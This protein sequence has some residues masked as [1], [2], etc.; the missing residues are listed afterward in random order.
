MADQGIDAVLLTTEPNIFWFTGFLTPFWHSPTRPWFVVVPAEGKPIAVIP[1]IG[2]S[3][4][5]ETWIDDIRTWPSP[6][7]AD[8]GVSLL[9][10]VLVD[11]AGTDGT[12]GVLKGPETHLRM[13]L[14]DWALVATAHPGQRFVD[15]TPLIRALRMVKSEREIAKIAYLCSVVSDAFENLGD[16]LSVG[17]TE[18]AAFT[19]FR[20][21]LLQRGADEVPYLVGASGRDLSSI[22]SYPCDRT[23]EPGDLLMF[24]TGARRD[25]YWCDFDRNVA[26]GSADDEARRTY[27]VVW[28]ATEAGLGVLRPGITAAELYRAM[29]DVLVEGGSEGND[30][31]RLGH[32]LGLQL[33]EWPSNTAVDETVLTEN[34]VMTLEPGMTYG[35]GRVMVHEENV[36]VRADGPQ[37][38]SRRAAPELPVL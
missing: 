21:D 5:A 9:G 14:A 18:R 29:A 27:E 31:G 3:L 33:T 22:I 26:F 35:P 37:L 7:P 8:D 2:A 6:Q 34:M 28:R 23:I 19:A 1:T 4:M 17:M 24:D 20:I 32:G 10:S 13:P 11:V 12:I 15:A 36:V 30:V 25:G 16:T 38:L